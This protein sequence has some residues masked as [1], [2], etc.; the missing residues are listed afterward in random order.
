MTNISQLR[1]FVVHENEV[2]VLIAVD[3]QLKDIASGYADRKL[4]IPDWIGE[5]LTEIDVEIKL[6]VRAE[7]LAKV[8]KMK[9]Q[10][11]ALMTNEEKRAKLDA[12]IAEEESLL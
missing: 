9:T 5:K 8:K 3:T 10:R 7:R 6:L 12:A 2:E 11:A 4:E 1:N